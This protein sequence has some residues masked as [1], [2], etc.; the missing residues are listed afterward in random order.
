MPPPVLFAAVLKENQKLE[1]QILV[2]AN[3]GGRMKVAVCPKPAKDATQS[4]FDNP[5]HQLR[6]V[7]KNPKY[8][9]KVYWVSEVA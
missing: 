3:H 6:R 2:N 5:K 1:V 9:N 8:N 7:N 4:C